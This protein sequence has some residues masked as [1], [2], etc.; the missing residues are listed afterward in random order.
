MP[1]RFEANLNNTATCRAF[2]AASRLLPELQ[3]IKVE[4]TIPV[5]PKCRLA[6]QL[7]T[8][9]R[10]PGPISFRPDGLAAML[11][12]PALHC[13]FLRGFMKR[14]RTAHKAATRL[15]RMLDAVDAFWLQELRLET[16]LGDA[17]FCMLTPSIARLTRLVV[18]CLPLLERTPYRAPGRYVLCSYQIL[19]S[20][21][22]R[23]C[24]V[25]VRRAG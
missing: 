16:V 3:H 9:R 23:Y 10:F 20:R 13:I 15:S 1:E 14:L 12:A 22:I 8:L 7:A 4:L 11:H 5:M 21:Q 6:P 24:S 18:H 2:I 19:R 17:A 25:C